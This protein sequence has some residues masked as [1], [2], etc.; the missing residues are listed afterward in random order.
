MCNK[1]DAVSVSKGC[2]DLAFMWAI[3]GLFH[4]RASGRQFHSHNDPW[5]FLTTPTSYH[6]HSYGL[7]GHA[8]HE[9]TTKKPFPHIHP[10]TL[11]TNQ[12]STLKYNNATRMS[13]HPPLCAKCKVHRPWALFR[14]PTV[15]VAVSGR[16]RILFRV[17][18]NWVFHADWCSRTLWS[19]LRAI[20]FLY[21]ELC[22]SKYHAVPRP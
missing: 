8:P 5:L 3:T 7:S 15:Y 2:F 21:A 20:H 6:K 22:G 19:S 1:S 9:S 10:R 4:Y 18:E 13:A 14:E 17:G 11:K 12:G 16:N